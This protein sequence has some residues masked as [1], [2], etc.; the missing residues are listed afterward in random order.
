MEKPGLNIGRWIPESILLSIILE[1]YRTS[2][3]RVVELAKYNL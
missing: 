1:L 2:K 3:W